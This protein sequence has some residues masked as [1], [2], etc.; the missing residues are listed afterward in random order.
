[1]LHR[2][3]GFKITVTV[4]NCHVITQTHTRL[5]VMELNKKQHVLFVLFGCCNLSSSVTVR[6]FFISPCRYRWSNQKKYCIHF[7]NRRAN[8]NMQCANGTTHFVLLLT[9]QNYVFSYL[10]HAMWGDLKKKKF[11]TNIRQHA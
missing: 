7:K 6:I 9:L 3:G 11:N 1:M 2:D 5:C 10:T 8:N 4:Y